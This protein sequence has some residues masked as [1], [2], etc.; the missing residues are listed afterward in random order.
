MF[1]KIP[2]L[3]LWALLAL[4]VGLLPLA[5]GSDNN[6]TDGSHVTTGG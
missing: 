2:A 3:A 4:T 1:K 5:C 6:S